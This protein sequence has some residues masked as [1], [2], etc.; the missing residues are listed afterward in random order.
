MKSQI[1][2][3]PKTQVKRVPKRGHYDFKTITD[4]LDEGL[5]CQVGF[6]VDSQPFVI[7][8]AY[9]RVG[10]RVYIHGAS[11]SRLIRTLQTGIDVCFTVTLLDGL[12]LARSAYHHSMNYRSVVL[13]G[14]AETVVEETEKMTALKAFTEHIIEGRWDQVRSPNSKELAET[15]VLSLPIIEASAKVRTGPPVDAKA[16]YALPVWAGVLPLALTP[17]A[18][19]PDPCLSNTQSLPDNIRTYA[20]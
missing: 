19:I 10:K 1:T 18:P 11:A 3:T 7:P 15:C 6:V 4:I 2:K 14:K 8:T 20:R 17:Q 9:G 13:F 5:V 12:V 16:D